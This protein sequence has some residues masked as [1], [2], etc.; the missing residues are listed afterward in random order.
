MNDIS[1][2]SFS[3]STTSSST[4]PTGVERRFARRFS[5]SARRPA[6][7]VEV[8]IDGQARNNFYV[9]VLRVIGGPAYGTATIGG[10]RYPLAQDGS[11]AVQFLVDPLPAPLTVTVTDGFGNAHGFRFESTTG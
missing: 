7:Q 2:L 10:D 4:S 8:R 5:A 3:I 1:A 6:Q 9:T 11:L